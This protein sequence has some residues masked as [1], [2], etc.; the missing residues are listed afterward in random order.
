MAQF[1]YMIMRVG[2]FKQ[3]KSTSYL[4]YTSFVK[5]ITLL[6]FKAYYAAYYSTVEFE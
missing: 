6:D 2:Y 1:D 5:Y 4:L 3:I